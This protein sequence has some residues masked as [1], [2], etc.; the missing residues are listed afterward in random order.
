MLSTSIWRINRPRPAPSAERIAISR[1]R[2]VARAS[3]RLAAFTQ[4]I[5]S[6]RANTAMSNPVKAL[7]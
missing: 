4:A 7:T 2:P 5:S 1:A 3:S 6:T